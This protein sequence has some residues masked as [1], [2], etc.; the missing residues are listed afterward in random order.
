MVTG[1]SAATAAYVWARNQV[2]ARRSVKAAREY[3]YW[4]AFIPLEGIVTG[5]IRIVKDLQG[6]PERVTFD[7]INTPEDQSPNIPMA[8]TIRTVLGS[9]GMVSRSPSPEQMDFLKDL[10]SKRFGVVSGYQI[11]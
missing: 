7:V 1:A 10:R 4:N 9:D 3:R 8:Q 11:N 6:P 2:E 5:Y